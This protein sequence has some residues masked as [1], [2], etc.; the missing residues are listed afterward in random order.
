MRST[1]DSDLAALEW[2]PSGEERALAAELRELDRSFDR[3][4]ADRWESFEDVDPGG[5]AAA[6]TELDDVEVIAS[7][8]QHGVEPWSLALLV[9]IDPETLLDPIDRVSYLQ[10]FDAVSAYVAAG[11]QRALVAV[12]G[13]SSSG[14]L[15][16]ERHVEHE[17]AIARRTSRGR[18]GRDIE[19]ARTLRAE[20]RHTAAALERGEV[21]LEHA[22]ALVAGTRHVASEEARAEIEARTLP[23]AASCGPSTF[24]KH[25][26]AA[27][28]AVDAA[29][30]A[31]RH[32]RAK[33]DRQVWVRR[34]GNGLGEL[35]VIDEWPV[36]NAMYE[37]ITDAATD[38]QRERRAQWR[39]A[40]EA[41][42]DPESI[43]AEPFDDGWVDRTLDNCRADAL[44]DLVLRDDAIGD[45]D[46]DGIVDEPPAAVDHGGGTPRDHRRHR[47]RKPRIEGRLV[48]DLAT[49]RGEAD[50]PC[51]LDGSP[52]PASIGRRIAREISHWRRMVTDPVDGHLLDYGK[53]PS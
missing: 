38:L 44:S 11:Q 33:G 14:D 17:V 48:I 16:L 52:I 28:C 40:A 21:T 13:G 31:R 8:V 51:L 2:P 5:I 25:V 19:L 6:P 42:T 43:A 30:E 49:L 22:A 32:A 36:V 53:S 45:E 47:R 37:R 3:V 24:R 12:A 39:A 41:A 27:V 50:H 46:D 20:F 35:H 4:C 9:A 29:D 23:Q 1:D 10:A 18:A 7:V 34:I 26:D 15:R